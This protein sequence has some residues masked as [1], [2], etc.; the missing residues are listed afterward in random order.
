MM[1]TRKIA[2][3]LTSFVLATVTVVVADECQ[4]IYDIVC[5]EANLEN[6]CGLTAAT[7]TDNML[8]EEKDLTVF[9]PTNAAVKAFDFLTSLHDE[10]LREVVLFHVYDR[11][12][13]TEDMKC[14]AGK[15][16]I[17][18]QS[19]KESRTICESFVPTFQKGGGNSDER[20]P[21]IVSTNIDACNGVIHLV[22]TVMLP[23][24]FNENGEI[25]EIEDGSGSGSGSGSGNGSGKGNAANSSVGTRLQQS[26]WYAFAAVSLLMCIY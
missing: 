24:G 25:I 20:K 18:M 10:K 22:D 23:G 15:N 6:F 1:M 5:S 12:L 16:R 13:H 19:G 8:S 9:A 21:V 7:E 14:A 4:S 17:R 11:A 3:I 2:T 26:S